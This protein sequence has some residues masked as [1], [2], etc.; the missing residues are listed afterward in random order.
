[1]TRGIAPC[2]MLACVFVGLGSPNASGQTTSTEITGI[3]T[4]ASGL[5]I[6]QA[7]VTLTRIDTGEVWTELTNQSGVYVFPLIE[8]SS[9]RIEVK[10]PSFKTTM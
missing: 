9:Y 3:V 2:L 5:P 6:H 1:M 4:D 8:P 10:A 7:A